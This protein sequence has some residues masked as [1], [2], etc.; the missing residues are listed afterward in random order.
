MNRTGKVCLFLTLVCMVAGFYLAARLGNYANSWSVKLR[1]ARVAGEKA[2]A[3]GETAALDLKV[4]QAELARTKLGWGYEWT[5]P[6]NGNVGEIQIKGTSLLVTGLG[7]AN[8]L[9]ERR[10]DVDGQPQI[11]APT[12]HVFALNG[13]GGSAY[14]GEFMA[15][16]QQLGDTNATLVPTWFVTTA[17]L[18]TWNFAQGVRMRSQV[19]AAERAAVEG[20]NQALRRTTELF[21][22]TQANIKEQQDLITAAQLQLQTRRGELLGNPALAPIEDRPEH[23]A[24]LVQALENL[25]ETRNAAQLKIDQLR[26]SILSETASRGSLFD[27]VKALVEKFPSPKSVAIQSP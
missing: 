15:D 21:E 6:P 8:G 3:A 5:F 10:V 27:E 23:T 16:P 20:L 19:P 2:V 12:V 25:E 11:V 1:D 18:G 26:R 17:E 24:G 22:E 4:A 13:Q 9:V 7:R 14:I